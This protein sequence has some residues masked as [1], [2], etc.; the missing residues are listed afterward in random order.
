MTVAILLG[1]AALFAL[2]FLADFLADRAH[3]RRMRFI[4]SFQ[5]RYDAE[6]LVMG[7]LETVEEPER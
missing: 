6:L 7:L 1:I 2:L 4:A 5:H 3:Q